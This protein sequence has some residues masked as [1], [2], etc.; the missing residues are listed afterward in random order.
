M[1]RLIIC[2]R[3]FVFGSQYQ[4]V[5]S[6]VG[7]SFKI[8]QKYGDIDFAD[9]FIKDSV[10][11]IIKPPIV[12]IGPDGDGEIAFTRMPVDESFLLSTNFNL[13][14]QK[15][16]LDFRWDTASSMLETLRDGQSLTPEFAGEILNAVHLK[17]LTTHTLHSNV[18]N[19]KDG[20]IYIYYMS[21]YNEVVKLN[22]AE[23]LSKGQRIVETRNL[24]P[25]RTA[26]AGDME[27][28]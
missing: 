7:S 19:L 20:D 24:F 5:T 3:Q 1:T 14:T 12:V 28:S 26:Q 2:S 4:T 13:A 15:G 16:P 18:I 17:T 27:I 25:S 23:E 10:H 6:I 8:L 9:L 11:G 22:I 21:I